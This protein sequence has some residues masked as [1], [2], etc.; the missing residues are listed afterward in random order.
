MNGSA[1]RPEL[2]W[3]RILRHFVDGGR[4]TRFDAERLGDHALNSTVCNLE[5]MGITIA[6]EPTTLQGRFGTI[7]CKVY[8]LAPEQRSAAQ[9]LLEQA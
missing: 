2:K 9:K 1:A 8:F 7:H 3:A 4:L 6:R 5:A